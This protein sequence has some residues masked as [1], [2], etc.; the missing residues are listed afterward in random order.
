MHRRFQGF[1][2][3]AVAAICACASTADR[4]FVSDRISVVARG[5][6]LDVILIPGLTGHR[7]DA[8][9]GVIETLDDRY[10]LHLVQVNGF[11][12][13]LPGANAGGP[14]STPV[15]E[16]IARYIREAGLGGPAVIGHS[17]GGTI[18][19]MLAARHPDAVGRLMVVDMM[20]SMGPFFGP[21]GET[22]EG[23]RGI[24]DQARAQILEAP[25]GRGFI[26]QV[27]EGMTLDEQMEAMLMR[28]ARESD[29]GTVANAFHE[30]IVT[31]LRPE[32]SRITA[33]VTVLYVQPPNVQVPPDEFDAS[34]AGLYAN[35]ADARLVRIDDSRHFI[36][37]DQPERFIAEIDAFMTR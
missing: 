17:M 26:A 35:A 9:G 6:G 14:V 16:E 24:A 27:F 34:M 37:W 12:G 30:L 33:P 11:A 2:A 28:Y 5:S 29:R 32:L 18:G 3:F 23:L 7:E 22:P 31:D 15:A 19:M 10:R 25:P 8:W 13:V 4:G 36:Q 20:P 21:A 1:A